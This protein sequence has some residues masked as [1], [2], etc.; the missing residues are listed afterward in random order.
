SPGISPRWR[1][2]ARR[3][4][5]SP[6]RKASSRA[7]PDV[8]ALFGPTGVGK[9]EVAVALAA[10]L[11]ERNPVGVSADAIAVYEGLDVLAAKPSTD[12]LEYRMVWCVPVAEESSAGR[13]AELAHPE[14]DALL[15]EGRLPIVVGGTGLYLRAAL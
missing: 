6:A 10:L 4:R 12:R 1:S 5:R 11:G 13:Y 2:P 8:V 7:L 3:R 15:Q 9:S 14:I